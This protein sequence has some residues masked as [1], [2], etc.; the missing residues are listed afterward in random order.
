MTILATFIAFTLAGPPALPRLFSGYRDVYRFIAEI[1]GLPTD[2][3][4]VLK[5]AAE[6]HITIVHPKQFYLLIRPDFWNENFVSQIRG[7][8]GN[9][10]FYVLRQEGRQLRLI[11][12]IFANHIDWGSR[13]EQPCFTV[14]SDSGGNPDQKDV[15]CVVGDTLI[16]E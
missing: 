16:R 6:S 14:A 13:N 5:L 4:S 12:T 3:D 2:P 8:H 9:G 10:P 7:A 1:E 15:Y 11:G